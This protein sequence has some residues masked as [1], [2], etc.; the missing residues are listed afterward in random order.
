VGS[1]VKFE[2]SGT[3]RRRGA[4]SAPLEILGYQVNLQPQSDL[5]VA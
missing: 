2:G 1:F 4:A 5:A 3:P